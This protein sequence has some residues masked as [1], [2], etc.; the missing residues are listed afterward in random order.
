MRYSLLLLLPLCAAIA[1]GEEH[2][3]VPRPFNTTPY[4]DLV[5]SNGRFYTVDE[6]QPRAEAV[7]IQNGKFIYVGDSAGIEPLIGE[8]TQQHDLGG[9]FVMPGMV[10]SH[11]HP[12]LVSMLG[13]DVA[14]GGMIP[15]TSHEN[16]MAWLEEYAREHWLTPLIIADSWPVALYG[17]EGPRKE[18][19]DEYVSIRPVL[20]FDDS[21]HS[22]WV[23]S[24]MLWLLGVDADTPDPA[25]GLSYFV[26]DEHGR[27]TGWAKEFAL[28]PFI[29]EWLLAGEKDREAALVEYLEFLASRGVTT[30][31]DAGNLLFHDSVYALVA[32]LEREGR[33]PVRYEGTYHIMFPDQVP[34]AVAEMRRLRE[35]YGG[36]LLRF[37]TVKIHFDGVGEI[38][39][40]AYLE[41][42]E[43]DPKNRGATVLTTEELTAFILELEQEELDLH[44]HV[45]GDR[46]TR[47]ALDAYEAAR[48]QAGEELRLRL[49]LSHLEVVDD[50]D[51]PRF[52]EMGIVANFTPHWHGTYFQGA[53]PG[54]G[55]QR[56]FRRERARSLHETGARLTFSSDVTGFGEMGRADPFYGMQI[57]H[58]RQDVGEEDGSIRPPANERLSLPTLLRGYTLNGA[59]Q[60]RMDDRIGSIEVGKLADA[61]VL[62]RNP[63]EVDRG[64]IHQIRPAAVIRNGEVIYGRL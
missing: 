44:L 56:W 19:I 49:T 40:A 45:V 34:K 18:D 50:A 24:S 17:T 12:G 47:I 59:Y 55:E 60:L 1:C 30:L 15:R 39:T 14:E 41:P 9:R 57:G 27:P 2:S 35:E 7:A 5:L 63:F 43:D 48:S 25:P 29:G 3:P 62:D 10:D 33:L 26:R 28:I 36:E 31:Y 46:A 52:A 32:K 42:Y 21:G 58:N 61:L 38:R 8:Q 23:N 16:I 53:R 11:T 51:S 37:N 54:L 6:N 22:F 20:L 13:P 64:A 4:A